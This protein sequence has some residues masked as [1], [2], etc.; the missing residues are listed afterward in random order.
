MDEAVLPVSQAERT[1]RRI[2]WLTLAFG[3]G[4]AV[5][6][7]LKFSSRH[8]AGVLIGAVLSWIN[9]LVLRRGTRSLIAVAGDQQ[10]PRPQQAQLA[11][12]LLAAGRYALLALAIYVIFKGLKIPLISIVAG[13]LSLGAAATLASVCEILPWNR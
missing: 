10:G 6:A 3:A 4:G 12:A 8:G 1:E 11:S 5:L 13:M 2:A 7:A 9:F